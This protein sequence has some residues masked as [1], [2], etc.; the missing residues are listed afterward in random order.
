MERLCHQTGPGIYGKLFLS[1]QY[2]IH[3]FVFITQ[4]FTYFMQIWHL[5]YLRDQSKSSARM[6]LQLTSSQSYRSPMFCSS[7]SGGSPGTGG[8]VVPPISACSVRSLA[9]FFRFP[10]GYSCI[11]QEACGWQAPSSQPP[12]RRPACQSLLSCPTPACG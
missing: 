8:L 9:A 10:S 11:L 12:G 5:S 2:S 1:I 4:Y 3:Q 6:L 7:H